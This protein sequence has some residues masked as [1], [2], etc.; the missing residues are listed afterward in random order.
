MCTTK[1]YGLF[2]PQ[3]IMCT[4]SW[5]LQT[6]VALTMFGVFAYGIRNYG[7]AVGKYLDER[8]QVRNCV[9]TDAQYFD[10]FP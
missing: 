1:R 5:S 10:S 7:P 8:N 9:L 6:I 3:E 2:I 4:L